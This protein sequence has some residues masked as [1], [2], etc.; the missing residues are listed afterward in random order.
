M[1]PL[2][3]FSK[4]YSDLSNPQRDFCAVMVCSQADGACPLVA[5]AALRLAIPYDDPKAFDDTPNETQ[6]YDDR[7][8]QIAREMLYLFSQAK[9]HTGPQGPTG[10]NTGPQGRQETQARRADKK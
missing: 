10:N 1:P 7:C 8:Q 4:V 9:E 5:G 6:K 2:D 3:C